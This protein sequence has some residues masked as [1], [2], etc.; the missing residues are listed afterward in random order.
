MPHGRAGAGRAGRGRRAV[1]V[2][3]QDD[4]RLPAR[5]RRRRRRRPGRLAGTTT[6][7]RCRPSSG[8]SDGVETER[9][10]GWS[11]DRVGGAHRHRRASAPTCPRSGPAAARCRSTRTSS[12]SC[13]CASAARCLRS[14]RVELADLEDEMEAMFDRGWTDGLPVVPPTEARV[15]RMLEGTT[16]APDEV[17]AVVP[18]DLVPVTVEKV[19]INAVHGRVPAR[20]P[21]RGARRGRGRLHRRVQHPRRARHHDAGRSGRR[22]QRP[23]PPGDRHELAASTRS[24]RATGPTSR[25]AGPCSSSSATSAAAARARSTGPRS[26]TRA[27]S[28]SASPRTRRARRGSRSPVG[29]GLRAGAR[30][31]HAVRRRGRRAASSTRQSRTPESLARTLAA[32]LRTRAPP[33]A[34][35]RLRRHPRRRSRAR[36]GV[37]RGGLEPRP[38]AWPSS[39]PACSCPAP[40]SCAAPA[41]SPRACPRR[42]RRRHAAEVPP[43]RPAHR[44]RRWRRRPVLGHHRRLGQ[45][46]R[47]AASRSPGRSAVSVTAR[48]PAI[49]LDPD[50][51]AHRG[52]DAHAAARGRPRSTGAPSALLDIT[53]PRGDVF[54]DRLEERLAEAGR[55]RPALPQADVHEAGARRPAPRDRHP[56]RRW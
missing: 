47:R 37:R 18:P 42:V 8:W 7:R 4:P 12:T 30:R 23:D 51:R 11:R 36:P 3:T 16:R 40:S 1:T 15:L 19:A 24:A 17:V 33:E 41:A 55:A 21:A 53:K 13:A 9:T 32:C 39:T 22:R 26:A 52:G 6:S 35:A 31:G 5:R 10:V 27:S 2:F 28:R 29:A 38:A 14:R 46:R 56:V 45:R 50:R 49:V 20:V 34:G 54:L 48:E 43:R 44:P 25:S